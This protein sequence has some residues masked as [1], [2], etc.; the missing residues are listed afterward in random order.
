MFRFYFEVARTAFRR[1]L[2]YRWAN[3]AGVL[4]NGFFGTIFS[5]VIIAL[6]QARPSVSGY[7]VHDALRYTWLVQS[8]VM[9]TLTFGWSDL[10]LTIRTGEVVSDLSKPCDFYGY[11]FSR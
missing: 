7:D 2:I 6:Y 3:L 4:T 1:Q 5:Y 11:W 8:L 10:I 9:T